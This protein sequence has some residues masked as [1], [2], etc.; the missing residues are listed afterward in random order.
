MN[1]R[2]LTVQLRVFVAH[3]IRD[4]SRL[5]LMEFMDKVSRLCV[6]ETS[7]ES[8]HRTGSLLK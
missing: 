2:M 5:A 6:D 4:Q 7:V 8:V 1:D 3:G